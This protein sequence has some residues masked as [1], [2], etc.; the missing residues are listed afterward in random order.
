MK[1]RSDRMTSSSTSRFFVYLTRC[2]QE[3]DIQG[4][5]AGASYP[6]R[7]SRPRIPEGER[8]RVSTPLVNLIVVFDA[9]QPPVIEV[10]RPEVTALLT[11]IGKALDDF[12]HGQMHAGR[13][14]GRT[15]R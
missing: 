10:G 14:A 7:A 1:K 3:I 15:Q 9:V 11:S 4:S 8:K 5:C 13:A 6:L 12:W 2:D